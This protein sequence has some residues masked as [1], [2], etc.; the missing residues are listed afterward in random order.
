MN[1][2][3]IKYLALQELGY[4]EFPDF[5]SETDNAVNAINNQYEHIYS[6][7]LQAF[8]WSFSESFNELNDPEEVDGEYK[9]K[10]ELP[11][12]LLYLRGVY[13]DDKG[14]VVRDYK[15]VGDYIYSHS[16]TLFVSYTIKLCEERLPAY[17]IEY[18]KYRIAR[19]LCLNLTGD[20]DLLQA[21]FASETVAFSD[22]KNIDLTQRRVRVL[23]TG[24]FT[25]VRF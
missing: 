8:N 20:K 19:Q 24:A 9:Y 18:L 13:L 25:D 5:D 22:A 15:I 1:R 10:F 6:L 12:D 16:D 7:A 23:P 3:E 4:V 21:I 14:S 17:F 11:S 2:N